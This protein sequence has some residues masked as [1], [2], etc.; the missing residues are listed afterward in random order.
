MDGKSTGKT[1]AIVF[2]III[3]L[4]LA[5]YIVYDKFFTE[6]KVKVVTKTKEVVKT[7]EREEVEGTRIYLN[8]TDKKG[9]FYLG[10]ESDKL[11]NSILQILTQP[12]TEVGTPTNKLSQKYESE[13][14]GYEGKPTYIYAYEVKVDGKN[15]NNIYLVTDEG[16]VYET[17]QTDLE[18]KQGKALFTESE[19][20]KNKEVKQL[21]GLESKTV[22]GKSEIYIKYITKDDKN[23]VTTE[24]VKTTTK[25]N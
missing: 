11:Y 10:I 16:K 13:V 2:L 7:P 17:T 15:V 4:G 21:S 5:G 24:S 3:I 6:E 22:N 8:T 9:I 20:F 25:A 12:K 19:L 14:T 1:V 23:E 18:T